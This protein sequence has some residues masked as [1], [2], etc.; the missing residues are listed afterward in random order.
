MKQ[1]EPAFLKQ[2]KERVGYKEGPD[3]ETKVK[4]LHAWA[5]MDDTVAADGVH[6]VLRW[7]WF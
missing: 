1:E 6:T 5:I 7:Y 3:V 4:R 2:F